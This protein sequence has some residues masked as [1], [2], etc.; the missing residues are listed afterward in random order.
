MAINQ[1][2]KVAKLLDNQKI[3]TDILQQES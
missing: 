3:I 1:K 2:F